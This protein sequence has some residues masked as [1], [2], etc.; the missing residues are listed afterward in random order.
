MNG[1]DE[2][3]RAGEGARAPVD[4]AL[5]L[6][7]LVSALVVLP[8][9]AYLLQSSLVVPLPGFKTAFGLENYRRLLAI[10]GW[11]L[12]GA[13]LAFALGSSLLA[14]GL[15]FPAA[16][17]MARTNVPFRQ[18]AFAGAF[19]SLS[20]PVIVKGVGWILL[21]G[22]NNGLIN[23]WLRATFGLDEPPI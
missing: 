6:F 9:F 11:Q 16:W 19:L 22:P 15:G 2:H 5:L 17:L 13:T 20:A 23:V 7:I 8:P 18:T 12:W 21:L 14:I 10:N 4:T 1:V 3:R